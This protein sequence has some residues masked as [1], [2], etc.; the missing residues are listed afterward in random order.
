MRSTMHH[1]RTGHRGM[2]EV[3]RCKKYFASGLA[4]V[5]VAAA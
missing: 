4:C 3:A 5:R 1:G 2:E